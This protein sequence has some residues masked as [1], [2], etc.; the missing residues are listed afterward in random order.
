MAKNVPSGKLDE[1]T[2]RRMWWAA[3]DTLQDEILRDLDLK[4]GIWLASPLPALYDSN[5]LKS[6]NGWVW[7]PDGLEA[8]KYQNIGLLPPSGIRSIHQTKN[9]DSAVFKR[10]PLH[11]EDGNDPF[12]MI[13]TSQVQ[14][15]LA[16]HGD[17]GQ[18]NLLIRTDY[19]TLQDLYKMLFKRLEQEKFQ[20]A[21]ELKKTLRSLLPLKSNLEISTIFWPLVAEKLAAFSPSLNIQT[22]PEKSSSDKLSEEDNSQISLLEAITHEVRTP[23]ATI[24]TLIRSLLRRS[25]I[26]QENLNRLKQ[27]DAE[28]TEQIDRFGLIFKAVE[29]ERN[30]SNKAGLAR[31]DLG[32]MLKI[33]YP[34]W[35][36]QLQRRG[37]KLTLEIAKDL[38][39]VLS[40]PEQLELM[41]GGL[42]DRNS[43]GLQSGESLF[44]EL[45][46]AGH[47]LKL[48]IFAKSLNSHLK[49]NISSDPNSDLGAVLSWDPSTGS[50]QLSQA[51]TQRLLASLGGRLTQRKEKGLTVFFPIAESR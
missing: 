8:L 50:L 10:L 19:E 47:R 38:P 28:C 29:L 42:I 12:L 44:L 24:R 33:M 7:S 14:V 40:N 22:L 2:V 34:V 23:L 27:I 43:R 48:R 35:R 20:D 4:G 11:T 5:L 21:L 45:S 26:S 25:D 46:P 39:H 9:R 37:L 17:K 32:N 41:L 6:F 18:R 3:L 51:A 31:T 36:H 13:I 1:S 16:L 30:Q 15:A 49:E